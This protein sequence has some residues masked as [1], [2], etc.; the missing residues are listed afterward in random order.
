MKTSDPLG[1]AGAPLET[2]HAL[3]SRFEDSDLKK[4]RLI[5]ITDRQGQREQA[6]YAALMILG[7]NEAIMSA[8]AFGPAYGAVGSQALYD[9]VN[10]SQK[11]NMVLRETVLNSS[12]FVRIVSEPD[13]TE[14]KQ[15]LAASNPTDAGIYL[16]KPKV[17]QD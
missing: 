14:I 8:T 6:R 13:E 17:N 5:L 16:V 7:S 10:W 15:L 12:D 11:H 4:S 3:L 2:L 9:L 1:V